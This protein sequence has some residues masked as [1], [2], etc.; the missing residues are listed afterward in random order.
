MYGEGQAR[1]LNETLARLGQEPARPE[2]LAP[3]VAA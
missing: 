1:T 3:L 2:D